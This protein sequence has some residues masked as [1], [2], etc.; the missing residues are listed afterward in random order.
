MGSIAFRPCYST[1]TSSKTTSISS[2]SLRTR[3]HQTLRA[4]PFLAAVYPITSRHPLG[5]SSISAIRDSFQR[6]TILKVMAKRRSKSLSSE[7]IA[8]RTSYEA[9]KSY[10]KSLRRVHP[11]ILAS[12][13]TLFTSLLKSITAQVGCS[14][15]TA[16][17]SMLTSSMSA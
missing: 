3:S 14:N 8:T 15:P 7:C 9:L 12:S 5:A 17:K 10:G 13:S 11:V 16:R 1:S 2:S 6:S 4:A